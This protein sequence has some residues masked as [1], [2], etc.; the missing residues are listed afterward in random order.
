[1]RKLNWRRKIEFRTQ[2]PLI[3]G[4]TAIFT[5]L[6][7]TYGRVSNAFYPR[8]DFLDHVVT[9]NSVWANDSTLFGHL[10]FLPR[11]L[12]GTV[13][14]GALGISDFS[15]PHYL[16]TIMP[17]GVALGVSEI[18]GRTSAYALAYLLTTS[19]LGLALS[20]RW[21][22]VVAG[23]SL[24]L[25]PYWP[26]KTWTIAALALCLLALLRLQRSDGKSWI[27]LVGLAASPHFAYIA[28]GGFL[29]PI[30]AVFFLLIAIFRAR[31]TS[32]LAIGVGVN[33]FSSLLSGLGLIRVLSSGTFV[34]HRGDWPKLSV[35]D[36]GALTS[37]MSIYPQTFLRGL[38]H[39]GTYFSFEG[40]RTVIY[41]GTAAI[42][43][44]LAGSVLL[45][46]TP[47]LNNLSR[48][49]ARMSEFPWD[50]RRPAVL[51]LALMAAQAG[52]TL[53]YVSE[54][55]AFTQLVTVFPVPFQISR[56]IS[57]AP[58]IWALIAGVSS[59]FLF[60]TCTPQRLKASG[61]GAVV[62][63]ITNAALN[64]PSVSSSI[65]T[66]L[67]IQPRRSVSTFDG[68]FRTETYCKIREIVEREGVSPV[69][70]SFGI[71][72]MI[73]VQNG[74]TALDG[75][76]YNY[77]LEYKRR[78]A[79]IINVDILQPGGSL[80]YFRDWG[81]RVYLFDRGVPARDLK[82]NWCAAAAMGAE[83]LLSAR[84]LPNVE[85][86]SLMAETDGIFV[87]R[88]KATCGENGSDA[89]PVK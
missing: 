18:L 50:L 74:F 73:S 70:L 39:Y 52:V 35:I 78:F 65:R 68:Y 81:S 56:V 79:R 23:L 15:I 72:P 80:K 25:M 62:V 36:L 16:Y 63:L 32:L 60:S 5:I 67:G 59:Y 13:P 69:A 47:W 37:A 28:W 48:G 44:S 57:L 3:V 14:A 6:L 41:L 12:G 66:T 87:Y 21:A 51:L 24:A 84:P 20:A 31:A 42:L 89:H 82:F 29:Q 46:L 8:H 7:I 75:Y 54:A 77:Q 85:S 1:M 22:G 11:V 27:W 9:L 88:I 43:L 2:E 38:Y 86:L 40:P 71:D 4:L 55:S 49:E 10:S 30:V 76:V 17:T 26:N 34:A 45:G 53:V 58:L 19:L 64:H 83:L 61:W 33:A